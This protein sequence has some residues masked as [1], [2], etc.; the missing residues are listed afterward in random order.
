MHS[1]KQIWCGMSLLMVEKIRQKI[2]VNMITGKIKQHLLIGSRYFLKISKYWKHW[3]QWRFELRTLR[4]KG[5]LPLY[6]DCLLGIP[7]KGSQQ[8]GQINLYTYFNNMDNKRHKE[9]YVRYVYVYSMCPHGLSSCMFVR[10]PGWVFKK[11]NVHL[12]A[13]GHLRKQTWLSQK[14]HGFPSLKS[15]LQN[16]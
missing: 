2:I 5:K 14:I 6:F 13:F 8:K 4:K 1:S 10:L 3:G 12:D 7:K 11:K 15:S 9:R 16:R